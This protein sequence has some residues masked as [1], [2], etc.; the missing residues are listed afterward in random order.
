[1]LIAWFAVHDRDNV[2]RCAIPW[3]RTP[4]SLVCSRCGAI[5]RDIRLRFPQA[6]L[7]VAAAPGG[8]PAAC[9]DTSCSHDHDHGHAAPTAFAP[10][11]AFA[12]PRPGA[13]FKLGSLGLGYYADV[14]PQAAAAAL[15]PP[16]PEAQRPHA[17]GLR[18]VDADGFFGTVRYVGPVQGS[19]KAGTVFG[20]VEWDDP[21]RGKHG[22]TVDGVAYFA[23]SHPTG[24]SLVPLSKL[25]RGVTFLE[26][27]RSTERPPS[28]D[29]HA[30]LRTCRVDRPGGVRPDATHT[31]ALSARARS[32]FFF[33]AK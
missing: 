16:P 8:T 33:A 1:M 25:L 19:K 22:G 32:I 23:T 2:K 27:L 17:P 26:A 24:G 29:Q 5:I 28:T 15:P 3:R 12:G 20:G 30:I 10:A 11:E 7:L 14:E 6:A 4:T 13:T 21:G 9:T 31:H 18:V